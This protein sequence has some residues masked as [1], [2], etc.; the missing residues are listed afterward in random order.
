MAPSS[1]QCIIP[2]TSKIPIHFTDGPVLLDLFKDYYEHCK[3]YLSKYHEK[4]TPNAVLP[5]LIS[6]IKCKVLHNMYLLNRMTYD[7][8]ILN[9][10]LNDL[11]MYSFGPDWAINQAHKIKAIKQDGLSTNQWFIN[12][13]SACHILA[14][15]LEEIKDPELITFL[16]DAMDP[17]LCHALSTET[18]ELSNKIKAGTIKADDSETF[19]KLCALI[20]KTDQQFRQNNVCLL[21]LVHMKIPFFSQPQSEFQSNSSSLSYQQFLSHTGPSSASL[22]MFPAT[23]ASQN[24]AFVN[25]IA[26]QHHKLSSEELF[27][28]SELAH[29]Y[30]RLSASDC[31]IGALSAPPHVPYTI[32]ADTIYHGVECAQDYEHQIPSCFLPNDTSTTA[33]TP[34]AYVSLPQLP[35]P[36]NYTALIMH[37][38]DFPP[39]TPSCATNMPEYSASSVVGFLDNSLDKSDSGCHSPPRHCHTRLCQYTNSPQF[40]CSTTTTSVCG[41]SCSQ[42]RDSNCICH[43]PQSAGPV[44]VMD[45]VVEDSAPKIEV[46]YPSFIVVLH[47]SPASALFTVPHLMWDC[48]I[49]NQSSSLLPQHLIYALLDHGSPVIL[50]RETLVT[51]LNLH[52]HKLHSPFVIDTATPSASSTSSLTKWVKFCLHDP[53]HH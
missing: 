43:H 15:L 6:E 4:V 50:I 12:V 37:H 47:S 23:F 34:V 41:Y 31:P 20:N 16:V 44:Y 48:I 51:S 2:G 7:S 5:K 27:I 36:A 13:F 53:S 11:H 24:T 32:T 9:N 3:I 39:C 19:A 22:P 49:D 35:L 21:E 29:G 28:L 46:H 10:F 1:I 25:A 52:H 45:K 18:N 17:G 8:M 14:G 38:H 33:R 30:A 40:D 42:S 26:M